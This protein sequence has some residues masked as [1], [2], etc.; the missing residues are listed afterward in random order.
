MGAQNVFVLVQQLP[1]R[2]IDFIHLAD[3]RRFDFSPQRPYA[4]RTRWR[5]ASSLAAAAVLRRA[6]LNVLRI[7]VHPPDIRHPALVKSI[8]KTFATALRSR[9]PGRYADLLN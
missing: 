1:W 3:P 9:R 7:G 6:P 8:E 5:L 4:S 2:R